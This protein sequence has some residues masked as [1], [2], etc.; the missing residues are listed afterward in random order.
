[1]VLVLVT[2][3][4]VSVTVTVVA[5]TTLTTTSC[6]P[7]TGV[8]AT[9][10]RGQ[11]TPTHKVGAGGSGAKKPHEFPMQIVPDGCGNE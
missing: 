3:Y 6:T 9:T 2:V 1:M 10:G 11:Y 8:S 7:S 5:M 4:V